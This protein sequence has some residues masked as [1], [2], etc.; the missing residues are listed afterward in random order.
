MVGGSRPTDPVQLRLEG[1]SVLVVGAGDVAG[2]KVE[3]LVAAGA[4]VTVVAPEV[5]PSLRELHTAGRITLEQ[6]AYDPGEAAEYRLVVAATGIREVEEQVAR[7][8]QRAGVFVN[9]ADVPD[10]CTFYLPA[11]VRRGRLQITIATEGAA[12]FAARRLRER[13]QMHFGP[14]WEPWLESA[15]AFRMAVL[16]RIADPEQRDRLFDRFM[17]ES[18]ADGEP[19]AVAEST[20][21]GW[22]EE[23]QP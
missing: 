20:W 11:L 8:A 12:P 14:N 19:V 1:Q 9:V 23:A 6:R 3:R 5:E 2:R 16:E 13:L 15:T 4:D 18:R 17:D 10:L 22:L 7:D 21:R